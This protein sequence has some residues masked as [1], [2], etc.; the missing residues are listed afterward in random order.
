MIID[1][2][3][4]LQFNAYKD[5]VNEVTKRTQS[6]NI[7]CINVGTN[8][9]SSKDGI[10]FA[11]KHGESFFSAI[12]LHPM[13]AGAE[14]LKI[15]NDD[16]ESKELVEEN[17]FDTQKYRE[18][19]QSKKVVAIGEIG[20]DYY[21]KPKTATKLAEFK[22]KQK[23]IFLQQLD[24]AKELNLPVILH[25]RMAHEDILEILKSYIVN[26]KS[27]NGVIHCFTGTI[28]Q[29]K[30]YIDL[31]FSIGINGI[32]FKFNIDEVIKNISLSNMLLETDCPYLTPL[33]AVAL[34]KAGPDSHIRNEPI[35]I[36]HTIQKIADLKGI[37][38]EEVCNKTTQNAKRLFTL[39]K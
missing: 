34:A 23:Q 10:L 17:T 28:E 37:T 19:A 30:K 31:G 24:L 20:L 39:V 26:H 25:C 32:I 35:F 14:F 27:M 4:H 13:Y 16:N 5:D 21:Y 12:G 38:F 7:W 11:E 22:E 18:L 3:S 6:K 8:Y 15:K 29:A 33:P 2:H 9:P 1:T 36:K